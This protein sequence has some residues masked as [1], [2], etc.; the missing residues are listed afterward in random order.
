MLS[1]KTSCKV[2]FRVWVQL[3]SGRVVEAEVTAIFKLVEGRRVSSTPSSGNPPVSRSLRCR[4][5]KP[6]HSNGLPYRPLYVAANDL[7]YI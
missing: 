7:D 6:H 1:A 4:H 5:S 3:Y 2:G